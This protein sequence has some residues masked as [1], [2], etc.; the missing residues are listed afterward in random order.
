MFD[1][2]IVTAVA[3]PLLAILVALR[4]VHGLDGRMLPGQVNYKFKCSPYKN[5]HQSASK[6][7]QDSMVEEGA[8]YE[9]AGQTYEKMEDSGFPSEFDP[10]TRSVR[11]IGTQITSIKDRA[12]AD[13]ANLSKIDLSSNQITVVDGLPFAGCSALKSLRLERNH[14][15]ELDPGVFRSL[16]SLV[17]LLLQSNEMHVLYPGMFEDLTN[18]KEL[19]IQNNKLSEISAGVL[20]LPHLHRLYAS[21]NGMKEISAGAFAS[22]THIHQLYLHENKLRSVEFLSGCGVSKLRALTLH[23]NKI[24]MLRND[25]FE[26]FPQLRQLILNNKQVPDAWATAGEKESNALQCKV[27]ARKSKGSAVSEDEEDEEDEDDDDEAYA[28]AKN[29]AKEKHVEFKP[30]GFDVVCKKCK[31][32]F[33]LH[34]SDAAVY[35][36]KKDEL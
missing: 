1:R 3:A 13:L 27:S 25:Q 9:C 28:A 18:L 14:I 21:K 35:C 36:L 32:S 16:T 33:G 15:S 34:K 4:G 22:S 24:T 23:K 30:P 7:V 31:G 17:S 2:S 19:Y 12:F 20:T 26:E 8:K 11:I 5:T 29:A 6:T 10:D